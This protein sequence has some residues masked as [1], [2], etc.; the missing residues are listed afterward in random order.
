MITPIESLRKRPYPRPK[1]W[2]KSDNIKEL[3]IRDKVNEVVFDLMFTAT[4]PL[5]AM[6]DIGFGRE[7]QG[8]VLGREGEDTQIGI[9]SSAEILEKKILIQSARKH[10]LSLFV[11]SEHNHLRVARPE[12]IATL[13]PIDNSGEYEA[14]LNTP[15]YIAIGF[16]DRKGVPI[17]GSASNLLTGHIFVNRGGKNY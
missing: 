12:V 7:R 13:D 1:D 4:P 15:P 3:S 11:F 14:G 2:K 17:A 16:F 9:D 5:R 10:G 6:I 8:E